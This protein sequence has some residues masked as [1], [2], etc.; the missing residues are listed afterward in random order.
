[1]LKTLICSCRCSEWTCREWRGRHEV[2]SA[3]IEPLLPVGYKDCTETAIT[4]QAQLTALHASHRPTHPKPL[5]VCKL[6]CICK[7][8]RAYKQDLE[9]WTSANLNSQK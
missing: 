7:M 3:D 9:C 1:M 2:H 5:N 4:V 6:L 8:Q